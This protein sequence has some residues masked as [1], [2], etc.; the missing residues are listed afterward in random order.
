MKYSND[1]DV[2][3]IVR[4]LVRNGWKY[5]TGGRH[6]KIISPTGR[7]MPVPGTPSDYR[8]L[9]N[10]KSDIRRLQLCYAI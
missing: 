8:A 10:F 4:E 6:G 5:H 2:A 9:R 3:T 7:R 1:M